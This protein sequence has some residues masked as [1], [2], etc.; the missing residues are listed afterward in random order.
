MSPFNLEDYETVADRL[1]RF[2]ADHPNGRIATELLNGSHA[3]ESV[4]VKASVWKGPR[5]VPDKIIVKGEGEHSWSPPQPYRDADPDATGHAQESPGSNPV[6][7]TSWVENCETSAI[8]RALA[9]MGYAPKGAR[10]SREE[11]AKS[12]PLEPRGEKPKP[13]GRRRASHIRLFEAAKAAGVDEELRHRITL[14]LTS[15][16]TQSTD[17]LT[18]DQADKITAQLNW[19]GENRTKAMAELEAWEAKNL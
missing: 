5:E 2:W 17:D 9:N 4:I 19:F 11:M 7:K 18:D 16:R 15:G 6:N 14:F 3:G 10:P 13:R 1:E 8:G 12:K